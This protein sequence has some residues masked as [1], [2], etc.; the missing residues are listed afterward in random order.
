LVIGIILTD[1]A[2]GD[3]PAKFLDSYMAHDTTMLWS[4]ACC[5]NSN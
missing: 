2:N 3:G 1:F 5:E 4:T